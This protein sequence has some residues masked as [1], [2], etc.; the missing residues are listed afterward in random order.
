M[1]ADIATRGRIV[2]WSGEG[3]RRKDIAELL[4]V[5]LPMVDR[6]KT[7]YVEQ[8]L[9]PPGGVV[10]LSIVAKTQIQ[11]LDR[12]QPVLPVAFAASEKRTAHHPRGQGVAGQE[13]ARP[14]DH[15]NSWNESA[16]SFTWTATAGEVGEPGE[17]I[18][19][20]GDP[21]RGQVVVEPR[22]GTRPGDRD[23]RG[24]Q[25]SGVAPGR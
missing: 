18:N 13:P 16:K 10:V 1:P 19:A 5:S 3:H 21:E 7:R 17:L 4:G 11:A 24:A 8:G 15:I 9:A 25:T 14:R 6:W 12:T 2:L 20:Q 22:E 23:Q